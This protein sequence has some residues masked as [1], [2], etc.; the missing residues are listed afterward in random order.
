R[1]Y[2]SMPGESDTVP[3]RGLVLRVN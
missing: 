3:S 1:P 2:A